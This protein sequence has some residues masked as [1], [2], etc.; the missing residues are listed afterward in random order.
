MI[1]W[2]AILYLVPLLICL[3]MEWEGF[4]GETLEEFIKECWKPTFIPVINLLVVIFFISYLLFELILS[5]IE[6][7]RE[8][9]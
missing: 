6:E 2:I 9:R 8:L 7:I 5:L 4:E 1:I 3:G